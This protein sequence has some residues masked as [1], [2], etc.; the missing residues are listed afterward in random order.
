[1]SDPQAVIQTV[2]SAAYSVILL[3]VPI[4]IR[5]LYPQV[6]AWL[7]AQVERAQS[8]L[9]SEQLRA[10]QSAASVAVAAV[11]QLRKNGA[12]LDNQHAFDTAQSIVQNWLTSRNIL[13]DVQA[14]RAVVESAVNDLPHAN[15]V[16]PTLSPRFDVVEK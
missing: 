11:E 16:Q 4:L 9:S 1:M 14:L 6:K 3:L 10:A 7:D 12:V 8:K 13:L 5:L 15:A 2:A